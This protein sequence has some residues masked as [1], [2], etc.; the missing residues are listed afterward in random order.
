MAESKIAV[1]DDAAATVERIEREIRER[2]PKI[3]R[4]YIESRNRIDLSAVAE[5]GE[6]VAARIE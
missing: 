2:F 4:I 1:T 6:L 5:A 3:T